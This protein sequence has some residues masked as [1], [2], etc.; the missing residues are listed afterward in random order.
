MC[1]AHPK[2][3]PEEVIQPRS[4]Q[5]GHV[6]SQLQTLLF[7]HSDLPRHDHVQSPPANFPWIWRW[8]LL[9]P[10]IFYPSDREN[11]K[12]SVRIH[13]DFRQTCQHHFQDWSRDRI[14]SQSVLE[15]FWNGTQCWSE[16]G[17]GTPFQGKL[18]GGGGNVATL[19]VIMLIVWLIS[20]IVDMIA[21]N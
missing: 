14:F 2:N 10:I 9:P 13:T 5:S 17:I 4:S 12:S 20:A 21:S 15:N 7:V 19:V 1:R 6:S 18:W 3:A 16:V 11:R 8:Y